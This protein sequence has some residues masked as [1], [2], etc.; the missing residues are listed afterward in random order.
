MR[1]ANA[2]EAQTFTIWPAKRKD[3]ERAVYHLAAHSDNDL[4][5]WNRNLTA[6]NEMKIGKWE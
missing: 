1:A 5:H 2:F 4:T 3:L 6:G